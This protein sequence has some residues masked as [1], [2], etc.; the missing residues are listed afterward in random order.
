METGFSVRVSDG[1][2]DLVQRTQRASRHMVGTAEGPGT[3]L[4]LFGRL[5]YRDD[6]RQRLA[7]RDLSDRSPI[8]GDLD[9]ALALRWYLAAGPGGFDRLEGDYALAVWDAGCRQLV[10]ARDPLGGF[11]LFYA[12][13]PSG[14]VADTSLARLRLPSA[15]LDGE[16]LADCLIVGGS[17]SEIGSD[18]TVWSGVRRVRPGTAI[19]WDNGTTSTVRFWSWIDRVERLR[20]DNPDELA[21]EVRR[22]LTAAVAERLDVTTACHLSGGLDSTAVAYLAADQVAGTG[23][24]LHAVSVVYA[25]LGTL[26]S[27]RPY[28]DDALKWRGGLVPHLVQGDSLLD[29]DGFSDAPAL[30]EPYPGLWRLPM[31]QATLVAAQE[32]GAGVLMTG[33]GG[34]ELFEAFPYHLAD[35]VRQGRVFT[36]WREAVTWA[37]HL[38]LNVWDVLYPF[39]VLNAWPVWSRLGWGARLYPSGDLSRANEWKLPD[40]LLPRF[41]LRYGVRERV[42]AGLRDQYARCQRTPLSMAAW[43][44]ERRS[45]NVVGWA[46]GVDAGLTV[47]HPMLD[48]R[49]VTL[50]FGLHDALPPV[51]GHLKPLLRHAVADLLPPSVLTRRTKGHFNELFYRGLARNLPLLEQLVRSPAA[52]AIEMIDPPRFLAT[53]KKAVVGALGVRP[54][55]FAVTALTILHWADRNLRR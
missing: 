2:F 36:A 5:Y 15:I 10:L 27:E 21:A 52:D 35:L 41:A 3:K 42:A 37:R 47:V 50:G 49:V 8:N 6:L 4:V 43:T 44:V 13:T 38:Q 45:G 32:A 53:L 14:V 30:D 28:V 19:I 24:P 26:Q 51:P 31:D 55:H 12:V 7:G 25:A 20:T 33:I 40:W 9:A 46:L 17:V 23:R 11:P 29:F 16:Y 48:P 18:R 34:D 1:R 54:L 22:R 39:G